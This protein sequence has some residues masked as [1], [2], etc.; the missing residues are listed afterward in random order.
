MSQGARELTKSGM[1]SY[2]LISKMIYRNFVQ[3]TQKWYRKLNQHK[4]GKRLKRSLNTFSTQIQAPN[5]ME[6]QTAAKQ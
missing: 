1:K 6:H 3:I 5:K 2:N 4:I